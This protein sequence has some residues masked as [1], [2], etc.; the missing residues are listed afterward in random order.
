MIN[1]IKKLPISTVSLKKVFK[2]ANRRGVTDRRPADDAIMTR[3]CPSH[4]RRRN[5]NRRPRRRHRRRR[6]RNRRRRRSRPCLA[7]CARRACAL[8]S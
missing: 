3:R 7:S 1:P 2:L 6:P 4:L 8:W 5:N